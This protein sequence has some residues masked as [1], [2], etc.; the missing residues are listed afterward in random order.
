MAG[1]TNNKEFQE[2]MIAIKGLTTSFNSFVSK[3]ST[4]GGE[5][6]K[7][8]GQKQTAQFEKDL[9]E[10]VKYFGKGIAGAFSKLQTNLKKDFDQIGTDTF[11][12]IMINNQKRQGSELA[13]RTNA[14]M[15]G[16]V[17]L[18]GDS[19]KTAATAFAGAMLQFNKLF[20]DMW[21]GVESA[22]TGIKN[23]AMKGLEGMGIGGG[24]VGSAISGFLDTLIKSIMFKFEEGLKFRDIKREAEVQLGFCDEAAVSFATNAQKYF[25]ALTR[26]VATEWGKA[27]EIGR[28]SCRERV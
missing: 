4:A 6:E 13:A 10:S 22:M 7:T 9:T 25:S 15:K 14:V 8:P 17:V 21:G 18:I 3:P 27:F 26:G 5:V 1:E 24:P 16:A 2:L 19:A 23:M 20:M 11:A 28:A 12:D